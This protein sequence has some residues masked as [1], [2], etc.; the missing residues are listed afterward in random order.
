MKKNKDSLVT[1]VSS[2][3]RHELIIFENALKSNEIEYFI[4]NRTNAILPNVEIENSEGVKI[5]VRL[6]DYQKALQIVRSIKS[7]IKK[8]EEESKIILR[9][10]TYQKILAKCPKCSSEAIYAEEKEGFFASMQKH[11]IICNA[12]GHEWRDYIE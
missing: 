12:C 2:A 4:T 7:E 6:D 11:D 9:N 8:Y 3:W 10:K 5:Q 1:L